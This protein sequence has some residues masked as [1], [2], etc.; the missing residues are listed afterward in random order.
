MITAS[1]TLSSEDVGATNVGK[2]KSDVCRK[3]MCQEG[4]L[5]QTTQGFGLYIVLMTE[6]LL[7]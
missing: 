5:D 7:E 1:V 2:Y 4:V 6:W 3:H